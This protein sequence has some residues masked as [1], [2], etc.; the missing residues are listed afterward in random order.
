[1]KTTPSK[2]GCRTR[3]LSCSVPHP[4]LLL[5]MVLS[6]TSAVGCGPVEPS[7]PET[8]R[9]QAQ[10]KRGDNGLAYNGLAYNGLAYNGLAY[11][12]LAYNGLASTGFREWFS[13]NRN[14]ADQVMTY[15]VRCAMSANQTLTY[16]EPT[17]GQTYT[18]TGSLG[19]TPGWASGKPASTREQQV[20]TA[21]LAA[22]VNRY[23][24]HVFFSMLGRD[25]EKKEIPT[26]E[27]ELVEYS[28]REACFFGNLFTGE[29]VYVGNNQGTLDSRES[30]SRACS[31]PSTSSGTP[32]NCPPMIHAGNCAELCTLD[33]SRKYYKECR[34]RG[35]P[36]APLTTRLRPADIFRCG[37]GVCQVSESCGTSLLYYS[38]ADC[39]TCS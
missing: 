24:Q 14:M 4:G 25:G 35:V 15:L 23:G 26:T 32:S 9:Q 27:T 39:G 18:W 13:Q 1:M 30:T 19:L 7:E 6:L 31:L 5:A 11:N 37:D 10:E 3:A 8:L 20:I 34:Y 12:G 28:Q 21:C 2:E 17:T 29:G 38:C 22:H 36:Y 33:G 16:T